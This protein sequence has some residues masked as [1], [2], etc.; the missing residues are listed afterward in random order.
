MVPRV[1]VVF[2][3]CSSLVLLLRA[4]SPIPKVASDLQGVWQAVYLEANGQK[5]SAERIQE[6]QLVIHAD[7]LDV[8]PDGE[9]TRTT[10]KVNAHNTPSTIDLT[11]LDGPRKG[12][13]LLGIY[14]LQGGRLQLCINIFGR[15]P[16]VRP[17]GFK[18][19]PGDGF[20]LATLEQLKSK[21]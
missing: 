1:V 15:D 10:F 7:R 3:I 20:V 17:T 18:T 13:R 9:G 16:T 14:S 5:E 19:Q 12:E 8:K 6:V 11:P 21:K 2:A 4:E